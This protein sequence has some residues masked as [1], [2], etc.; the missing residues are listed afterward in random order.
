MNNEKNLV[1][2]KLTIVNKN[3]VPS[4]ELLAN[5]EG[6]VIRVIGNDRKAKITVSVYAEQGVLAI[7]DKNRKPKIILGIDEN[8]TGD[9]ILGEDKIETFLGQFR[10]NF[11]L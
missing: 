3:G 9:I 11:G 10:T 8:G 1:C 7:L 4:L 2:E 6:G 5:E